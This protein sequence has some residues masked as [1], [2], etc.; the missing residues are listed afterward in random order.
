MKSSLRDKQAKKRP[1]E[2]APYNIPFSERLI[3]SVVCSILKLAELK[4]IIQTNLLGKFLFLST[5]F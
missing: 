1:S 4:T 5:G 3:K 2:A